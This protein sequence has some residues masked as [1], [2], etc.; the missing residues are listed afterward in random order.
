[1]ESNKRMTNVQQN[2][3][4][5]NQGSCRNCNATIYWHRSAKGKPYPTD[6]ATDRK[7]F[8]KC[9]SAEQPAAA[10]VNLDAEPTVVE[11]L[12]VLE[13]KVLQLTRAVQ[14]VRAAQPITDADLPPGF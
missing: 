14:E 4:S 11:R 13:T 8:H 12:R 3:Y 10:E 6:S 9:G 1:M 7:A 2:P 5:G